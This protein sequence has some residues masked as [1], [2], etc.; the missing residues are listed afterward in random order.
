MT[1]LRKVLKSLK[2]I[3]GIKKSRKKR[4]ATA[5]RKV[6]PSARRK[7]ARSR[8]ITSQSKA[9]KT[10]L[11]KALKSPEVKK[12]T[13]KNQD[14]EIILG[15]VLGEV[16]HFFDRIQV[17]V[18]KIT[19]GQIKKGDQIVMAGKNGKFLQK[20]LSLQIESKDVAVGRRGQ[21]VG[22]KVDNP[23]KPGDRVYQLK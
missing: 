5:T 8:P 6:S 13:T 9:L 1:I 15:P 20:V 21:L 22:L 2:K 18:I 12:S 3:F 16:T 4:K 7:S 10:N 19:Q 23:V 17:C 11:K 14:K